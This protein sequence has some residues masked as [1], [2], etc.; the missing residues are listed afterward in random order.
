MKIYSKSYYGTHHSWAHVMRSIMTKFVE[1]DHLVGIKSINEYSYLNEELKDSVEMFIPNPDLEICY[2]LPRNF[3]N[4]F[5]KASKCKMA[6]YNYES[7]I[8]PYSWADSLNYIDFCLPSS[9]Y[10]QEIFLKAGW[11]KNKCPVIPHGI[12]LKDYDNKNHI[13]EIKDLRTF[14][15]LSVAISHHRK[16]LDILIDAYYNTFSNKDNVS[17]IIKNSLK[18]PE[19]YFEC[20][21]KEILKQKQEKYKGKSLPRVVLYKEKL[22]S[23]IELYNSVDCLINCSSGEGFGLPLLEALACKKIVIATDKGGQVDFL[24][25]NNSL[26]ISSSFV[27]APREHQYWIQSRGAKVIKPDYIDLC[28]K[29]L[30]AYY[31]NKK[32]LKRLDFNIKKEFTWDNV[33]DR[34]LDLAKK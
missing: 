1:K 2:T 5:K 7:S 29:M 9:K 25:K 22:D 26:L 24:N 19:Q 10:S 6:V 18:K 30:F 13:K 33:A 4:R 28:D 32:L 15:F 17:L 14:N 23:M 11:D 34:I 16:N 12:N 8:L 3:S 21:L 31:N 20:D 27:D